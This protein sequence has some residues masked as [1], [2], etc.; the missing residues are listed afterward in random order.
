MADLA[1]LPGLAAIFANP[2]G[3]SW[4]LTLGPQ[5]ATRPL[6]TSAITISRGARPAPRPQQLAEPMVVS[7]GTEPSMAVAENPRN[8]G[9]AE[10]VRRHPVTRE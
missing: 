5:S 7:A 8:R 2:S 1:N 3:I 9:R 10:P 6:R 4:V